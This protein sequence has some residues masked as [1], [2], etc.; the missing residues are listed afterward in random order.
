MDGFG[1]KVFVEADQAVQEDSVQQGAG[2]VRA[3]QIGGVDVGVA[4][5]CEEFDD[6]G[7]IVGF[8]VTHIIT[9]LLTRLA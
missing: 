1:G 7:F 8:G 4:H 6:G 2:V 9:S 5:L 3:V